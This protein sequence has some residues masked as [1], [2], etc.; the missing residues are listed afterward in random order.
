MSK[1][2]IFSYNEQTSAYIAFF[3]D[4]HRVFDS[5][6]LTHTEFEGLSQIIDFAHVPQEF[7]AEELSSKVSE[8]YFDTE[9]TGEETNF[10]IM[11]HKLVTQI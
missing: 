3:Y 4:N 9:N 1:T 7:N 10:E 11:L 2:I 8:L 6:T 5:K